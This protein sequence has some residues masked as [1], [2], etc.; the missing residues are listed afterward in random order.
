M[1]LRTQLH[2]LG[3]CVCVFSF[4]GLNIKATVLL[5]VNKIY[6][7]LKVKFCGF[8]KLKERTNR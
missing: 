5:K 3:V 8:F 4:L 7:V 6:E 1:T 2:Y